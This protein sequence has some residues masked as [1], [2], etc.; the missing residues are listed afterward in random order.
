MKYL[1]YQRKYLYTNQSE[2]FTSNGDISFLR[3]LGIGVG[4][5]I[6]GSSPVFRRRAT[7]TRGAAGLVK[8]IQ[9]PS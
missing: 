9:N 3:A 8:I 7:G 5:G 2:G 4:S 1:I 6:G